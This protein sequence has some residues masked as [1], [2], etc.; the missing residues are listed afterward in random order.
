VTPHIHAELQA[1]GVVGREE[2]RIQVFMP[3][4]SL[5]GADRA[6]NDGDVLR[7]SRDSKEIHKLELRVPAS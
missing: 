3:R 1:K 6:W 4:Q 2:H 5:T 7:Y